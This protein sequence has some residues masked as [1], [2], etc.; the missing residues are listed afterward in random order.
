VPPDLKKII[1]FEWDAGNETKSVIKH[2]VAVE[3]S[4]QIFANQPLLLLDDLAHS[5]KELRYHAF[6]KTNSERLLRVT[7]T[8]RDNLVR[9]ISARPMNRR[10]R[11]MYESQS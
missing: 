3:E 4:E 8:I 5:E 6:G 10:E 2:D 1:G 7:F 11:K 9:V